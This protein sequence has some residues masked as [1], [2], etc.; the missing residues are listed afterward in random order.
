MT[1]NLKRAAAIGATG[2]IGLT[3][4]GA[5]AVPA[6]AAKLPAKSGNVV[7]I[8]GPAS[9]KIGDK[10]AI[11]CQAPTKLAG[12]SLIVYQNGAIFPVKG[13]KVGTTGACNFRVVSGIAGTNKFDVAVKKSGK[14]YQSNSIK[15]QLKG[16]TSTSTKNPVKISGPKSVKQWQK[17]NITC[18][19]PANTAGGKVIIYQNGAIFPVTNVKVGSGGVC[20]FWVKSGVVGTNKFDLAVKKSGKVYQSNAISVNVTVK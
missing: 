3:I 11:K 17:I 1:G 20:N 19:A 6:N 8:S 2:V 5:A 7:A 9:A 13:V 15:V 16:K 18:Q 10:F 14:V 12:G 4:V